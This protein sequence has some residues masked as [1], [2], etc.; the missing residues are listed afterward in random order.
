MRRGRSKKQRGDVVLAGL[1]GALTLSCGP[2]PQNLPPL[3]DTPTAGASAGYGGASAAGSGG[4]ASVNPLGR[5]RCTAPPGTTGSPR[6]IEEAVTLLNALPKPTSVACF[7]E[8]LD[9]PFTAYATSSP[10]SAQPA[11]SAHSPRVF[12][13]LERLWLSVVIDGD[14]SYLI[15]FSYLLDELHS[16]KGELKAP[17][18]EALAASAPYD[19]VRSGEGTVCGICHYGE[20]RVASVTFTA[21]YA[22]I[23]FRPRPDSRVAL[24][25]L[26]A[27][28]RACDWKAEPHRCEMLSALF[29][30]GVVPEESFPVTM[31]TFF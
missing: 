29:D 22:S 27:E 11:L 21:A 30:N 10:F 8:S 3:G 28:A 26:A 25:V 17:L 12:I 24:D 20:E 16:I 2:D 19:R 5:A 1:V 15:E 7:V 9:R 23:P 18:N 13:K 6:T 4:G 31:P 14:S